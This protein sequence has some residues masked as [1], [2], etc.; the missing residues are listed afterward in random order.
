MRN[1]YCVV[2]VLRFPKCH[3]IE[4]MKFVDSSDRVFQ[5]KNMHLSFFQVYLWLGSSFI[6]II[7]QNSNIHVCV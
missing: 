3:M 4:I 2:S 5:L 7:E 1:D 6:F